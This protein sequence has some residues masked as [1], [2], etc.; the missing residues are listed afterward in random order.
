MIFP[1]YLNNGC[2]LKLYTLKI[3]WFS[4]LFRL[5]KNRNSHSIGIMMPGFEDQRWQFWVHRNITSEYD[6]SWRVAK[7]WQNSRAGGSETW[8][9]VEQTQEFTVT[10]AADLSSACTRLSPC[11]HVLFKLSFMILGFLFLSFPEENCVSCSGH[12][13]N[14]C[15][16]HG[17]HHTV[18]LVIPVPLRLHHE[19]VGSG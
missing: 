18:W 12:T 3:R 5:Y 14:T 11:G 16:A 13:H 19:P 10:H 7:W 17:M 4:P 1:I 8:V 9:G 15:L 2:Y 6:N